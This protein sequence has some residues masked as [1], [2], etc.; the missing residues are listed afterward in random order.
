[1]IFQPA[2]AL[3]QGSSSLPHII[4]SAPSSLVDFG[5]WQFFC[6]RFF[7]VIVD[8]HFVAMS[9]LCIR[10]SPDFVDCLLLFFLWVVCT[11]DFICLV[12]LMDGFPSLIFIDRA[13]LFFS[14]FMLNANRLLDVNLST[15]QRNAFDV[16]LPNLFC[17]KVYWV[18]LFQSAPK[19]RS[20]K[21]AS[22][23]N[24]APKRE[25]H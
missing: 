16:N 12:F 8:F 20:Q 13:F 21:V 6:H 15:L 7:F 23:K 1:M 2:V 11:C 3:G 10:F 5:R 9:I 17:Y 19:Q 25:H 18:W 22:F 4:A 14:S 24:V